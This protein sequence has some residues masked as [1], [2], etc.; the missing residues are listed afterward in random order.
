MTVLE[1]TTI[2]LS[3]FGSGGLVDAAALVTLLVALDTDFVSSFDTTGELAFLLPPF[4]MTVLEGTTILLSCFGSGG[5]V[6]AAALVTMV[7]DLTR[8]VASL[9]LVDS[10]VVL[11]SVA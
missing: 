7:F 5:L 6:D 9:V 4:P 10:L 1:G 8:F 11:P 3:C 2:L